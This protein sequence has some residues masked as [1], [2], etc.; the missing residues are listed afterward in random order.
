MSV[1]AISF[2]M[3]VVVGF[4]R[5][6][7]LSQQPF[8]YSGSH[9]YFKYQ[10]SVLALSTKDGGE[11]FY[12]AMLN[13]IPRFEWMYPHAVLSK[14]SFPRH[15][16]LMVR[17]T[18]RYE[19]SKLLPELLE[20]VFLVYELKERIVYRFVFRAWCFAARRDGRIPG[21]VA[22]QNSVPSVSSLE[23]KHSEALARW[24]LDIQQRRTWTTQTMERDRYLFPDVGNL[25]WT[26]NT[27]DAV[28]V[29]A[30]TYD[31]KDDS[32]VKENIR[33]AGFSRKV[34]G[35]ANLECGRGL[36]TI[37]KDNDREKSS[38][39]SERVIHYR[40]IAIGAFCL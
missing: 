33:T 23:F 27:A 6:A 20:C 39:R 35:G 3:A 26:R 13:N 34:Y 9:P 1:F 14:T 18:R 21:G 37:W 16:S 19:P 4:Y 11:R 38:R 40:G 2:S 32:P 36:Y 5:R 31:D 8:A 7:C 28:N 15:G 22:Q 29:S 30:S 24:G 17:G 10:A 25:A 12:A